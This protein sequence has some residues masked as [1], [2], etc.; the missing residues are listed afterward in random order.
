MS[1]GLLPT[2]TSRQ[3][4]GLLRNIAVDS[5]LS[6]GGWSRMLSDLGCLAAPAALATYR[7]RRALRTL[8]AAQPAWKP[9]RE[10]NDR[11]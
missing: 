7:A 3:G 1:S 9:P 6:L 11:L 10:G 8:A 5:L 4:R 2:S